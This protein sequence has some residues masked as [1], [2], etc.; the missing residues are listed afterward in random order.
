MFYLVHVFQASAKND[1]ANFRHD[2]MS[3]CFWRGHISYV[4]LVPISY[5]GLDSINLTRFE[6]KFGHEEVISEEWDKLILS[7]LVSAKRS[8]VPKPAA[9]EIWE[10]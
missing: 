4:I 2:V 3:E 7:S 9:E 6:L 10:V 5:L 8:Y 1:T